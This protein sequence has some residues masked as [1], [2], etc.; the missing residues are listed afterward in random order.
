[1][2]INRFQLSATLAVVLAGTVALRAG[3]PEIS[4]ELKQWHKVT[5]TLDGPQAKETDAGPNPFVDYRMDVTFTH[6]SGVPSYKVP[7]YFAADGNAAESSAASGSKW[8]AHLSPD[9]SGMWTYRGL[10]H[11]GQERG[12]G[13]FG[14]RHDPGPL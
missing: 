4:G 11:P 10:V 6:K 8:R 13:R 14:Q 3:D 7:G 1:M 2:N 5:L 12:S 9:K